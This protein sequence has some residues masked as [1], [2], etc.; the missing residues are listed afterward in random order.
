M[1]TNILGLCA[2]VC[3]P[4]FY[5]SRPNQVHVCFC[6]FEDLCHLFFPVLQSHLCFIKLPVNPVILLLS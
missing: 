5:S 3:L 2:G 6:V 4:V 1:G